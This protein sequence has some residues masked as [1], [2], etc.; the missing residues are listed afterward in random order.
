MKPLPAAPTRPGSR[1]AQ[2][3][4]GTPST[5]ILEQLSR[6]PGLRADWAPNEKVALEVGIGA[7]LAGARVLVAMKHVGVNVA[8]DPLLTFS[9][10]RRWWRPAAGQHR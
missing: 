10:H 1:W 6:Y 3:Y 8:A 7:S 9:L 2:P 5:E 4:P